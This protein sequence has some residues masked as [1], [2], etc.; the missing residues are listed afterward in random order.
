MPITIVYLRKAAIFLI[1]SWPVSNY[2]VGMGQHSFLFRLL[3]SSSAAG[4]NNHRP[5]NKKRT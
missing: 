1:D 4:A 3:S 5:L 2:K